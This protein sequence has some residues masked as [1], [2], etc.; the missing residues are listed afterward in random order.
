MPKG[1]KVPMTRFGLLRHAA[2]AWNQAKRIQGRSDLPLCEQ[3][4]AEAAAWEERLRHLPW[5]RLVSSP[6][7]RARET[8]DRINQTLKLPLEI[9][10]RLGEQ[11]WG[12]WEGRELA[13]IETR[14]AATSR[15]PATQGWTFRPPGG[16]SR[17]QV[18]RRSQA[19]LVA[20][21]RRY[22]GETLLV[23]THGGVLKSLTYRLY[24]RAFMPHEKRLLK[25]HHLHWV[26]GDGRRLRPGPINAVCR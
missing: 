16:E 19:A 1:D 3:G 17:S 21:S 4:R 15:G 5:D 18:W 23:V 25:S 11:S 22:P 6:L 12:E 26:F 7:V 24:R 20:L 10:P 9:D 8:A 2:T 13:W 14:L